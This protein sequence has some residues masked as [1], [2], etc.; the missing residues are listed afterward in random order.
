MTVPGIPTG[1]GVG[2]FGPF[3]GSGAF[4]VRHRDDA[5]P[6]ELPAI[7]ATM[8]EQAGA[9]EAVASCSER[10]S[11]RAPSGSVPA[12][13]AGTVTRR[14]HRAPAL[15][16]GVRPAVSSCRRWPAI[17]AGPEVPAGV[18]D[19]RPAAA[20]GIPA[21]RRHDRRHGRVG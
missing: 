17:R 16:A 10:R 9:A 19:G 11:H 7:G 6:A 4:L 15:S 3:C 8:V 5:E 14:S 13:R 12:V 21:D 1:P 20:A 2:A 18:A